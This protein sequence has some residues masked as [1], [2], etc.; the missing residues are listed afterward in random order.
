MHAA[1]AAVCL[2]VLAALAGCGERGPVSSPPASSSPSASAF[3]GPTGQLPASYRYVLASACGERALIGRY[4]VVVRDGV[5]VRAEP[6]DRHSS[7]PRLADVPTLQDLRTK[8]EEAGPKAVVELVEDADG[9]P[10]SLSIDH[11]PDAIDDEECY[12]VSDLRLGG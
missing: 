11:L 2:T 10:V 3:S 4:D 9:V 12:E 5:V 7:R 8:A 6:H 1:L